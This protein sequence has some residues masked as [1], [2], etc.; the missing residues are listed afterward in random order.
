MS[1]LIKY[2]VDSTRDFPNITEIEY[3]AETEN[4]IV[5]KVRDAEHCYPKKGT[6][7]TYYD[8]REDALAMLVSVYEDRLSRL[9][10][11]EQNLLT[12]MKELRLSV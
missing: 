7:I 12:K 11:H 4:S 1:K 5:V 9:K 3:L 8:S 6:P 2:K 10:D